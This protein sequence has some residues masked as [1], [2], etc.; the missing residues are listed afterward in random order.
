[1][2]TLTPIL[3]VPEARLLPPVS[4]VQEPP[5]EGSELS[6]P[7]GDETTRLSSAPSAPFF[8]DTCP[9]CGWDGDAAVI[10]DADLGL[11]GWECPDC[12]TFVTTRDLEDA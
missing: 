10:R 12:R 3:P 1:M 8:H 5:T 2:S 9:E 11:I 4:R 6:T 7:L